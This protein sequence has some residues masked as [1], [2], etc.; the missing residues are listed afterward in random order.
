MIKI[1][2]L[3]LI[4]S[5]L[6]TT[7]CRSQIIFEQGYLINEDDQK[8]ECLIKNIEWKN[9]PT[10]FEYRISE[11][12]EIFIGTIRDIK[13]FGIIGFSKYVR[14]V[15]KIDQSSESL[16]NLTK[17]KKPELRDEQL[18]LKVLV[19][20]RASLFQYEDSKRTKFFIGSDVSGIEQLIYKRYFIS[21][22]RVGENNQFRQQIFLVM[23]GGNID[24]DEIERIKYNKKDLV[25]LFDKYN[26]SDTE[27]HLNFVEQTNKNDYTLAIRPGLNFTNL[28]IDNSSSNTFDVEFES[29]LAFRFGIENEFILPFNKNK[30]SLIV[31]PTYQ[32]YKSEKFIERNSGSGDDI[33]AQINFKSLEIPIGIRHYFFLKNGSKIFINTTYNLEFYPK[34][35]ITFVSTSGVMLNSLDVEV[36]YNFG[37]GIGYT[38]KDRYN[39][40]IRHQTNQHILREY[41]SW[42]S[43][44]QTLSI[45][46]SR[47][48]FK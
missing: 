26:K 48:L 37:L 29:S 35:T 13:E 30:W 6:T 44:F 11:N 34:T 1:R 20:G 36:L 38:I 7:Y 28:S 41:L 39:L 47:S 21:Q 17:D 27:K 46:F 19:E 31:E 25:R 16:N 24:Q 40:E 42:R 15:V 33:I 14:A 8:I 32:Y 23:R 4:I 10:S 18:F 43:N 12:S 3:I 22:S 9:N 2:N 45:I 5:I